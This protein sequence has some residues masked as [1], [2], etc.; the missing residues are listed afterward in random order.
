[1]TTTF[2]TGKDLFRCLEISSLSVINGVP[3][4]FQ[5]KR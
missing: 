3:V 1:M 2:S 4:N 5:D